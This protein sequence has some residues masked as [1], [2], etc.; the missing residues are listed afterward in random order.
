M[1]AV[2]VIVAALAA[3]AGAG[4]K[5]TASA[6]VQDAY[7]SL[8]D[9]LKGKLAG[10][11]AAVQALEADETESDVWQGR[12]GGA[13]T[14]AGV[15]D[16]D[17]ILDTARRLLTA[18]DPEKAKTLHIDVGANYGAVGGE[19]SG[20]VT[21]HQAPPFPLRGRQRARVTRSRQLRPVAYQL[22][23]HR[24]PRRFGPPCKAELRSHGRLW[25]ARSHQ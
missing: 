17:Q 11:A 20:P 23:R 6:A 10:R 2:E 16:D 3:G 25:S 9:I 15:A 7:T 8:K 4:V 18:A 14:A 19:F 24:Q 21:F 13:L 22:R 1:S 5:D 12:I